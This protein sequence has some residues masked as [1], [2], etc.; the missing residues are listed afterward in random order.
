MKP[1]RVKGWT[2][3]KGI[4]VSELLE[5][6]FAIGDWDFIKGEIKP[7]EGELCCHEVFITGGILG[8]NKMPVNNP[9]QLISAIASQTKVAVTY[10]NPR[11]SVSILF[12]KRMIKDAK[13]ILYEGA[14]EYGE[15]TSSWTETADETD[16]DDVP[17][18]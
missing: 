11:D 6:D 2:R 13:I 10:G 14:D 17:E 3:R 12:S 8:N 1:L 4:T 7:Y 16:Y 9:D 5:N 18:D 15:N